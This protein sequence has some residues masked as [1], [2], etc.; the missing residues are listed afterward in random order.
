M[1]VSAGPVDRSGTLSGVGSIGQDCMDGKAMYSSASSAVSEGSTAGDTADLMSLEMPDSGPK[2]TGESLALPAYATVKHRVSRY[3]AAKLGLAQPYVEALAA[4]SR[5]PEKFK[6][7]EVWGTVRKF[8]S[9]HAAAS[10]AER[11]VECFIGEGM[12]VSCVSLRTPPF[13]ARVDYKGQS[14]A[15]VVSDS[16]DPIGLERRGITPKSEQ[17]TEQASLLQELRFG[18][19]R[20]SELGGFYEQEVTDL[21]GKVVHSLL[22]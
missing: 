21:S 5:L 12:K 9:A 13:F 18:A 19:P 10:L 8:P 14:Y 16:G 4:D 20:G 11:A 7:G 1:I 2:R 17:F 22:F 15:V 6:I 3:V